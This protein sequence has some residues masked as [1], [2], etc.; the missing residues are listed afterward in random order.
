MIK[1]IIGLQ[2]VEYD[3]KDGSGHVSGMNIFIGTK[4]PDDR[5]SGLAVER[6]YLA[7]K[8]LPV[9]LSLGSADIEYAKSFDGKAYIERI[10]MV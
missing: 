1:E 7:T 4:I 3:K 6:E 9:N 10:E 5:G 8:N 2:K